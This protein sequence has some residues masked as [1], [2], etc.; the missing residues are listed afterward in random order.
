MWS[1]F[2]QSEFMAKDQCANGFTSRYAYQIKNKRWVLFENLILSHDMNH[3]ELA[4]NRF[5][6]KILRLNRCV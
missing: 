1:E 2:L 6:R 5:N 4:T 3:I